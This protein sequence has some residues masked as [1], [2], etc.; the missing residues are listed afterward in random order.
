MTPKRIV[1]TARKRLRVTLT[2]GKGTVVAAVPPS[3]TQ[4]VLYL[5]RPR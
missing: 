2:G 5:G 4:I 3:P 1:L